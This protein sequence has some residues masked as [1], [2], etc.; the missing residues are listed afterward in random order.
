MGA[1]L[2][3]PATV[4]AIAGLLDAAP[5][6]AWSYDGS[7]DNGRKQPQFDDV[8]SSAAGWLAAFEDALRRRE[9]AAASELF[10]PD[11]FWRDIVSF[12][13]HI[14][15]FSGAPSI[16]ALLRDTIATIQPRNFRLDPQRTPPRTV[17]RAGIIDAGQMRSPS[18]TS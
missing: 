15:T 14:E 1:E 11:G 2:T 12:T 6:A 8:A 17:A 7:V 9:A 3:Y 4:S 5:H 16:E 10:L 13:W 18:R